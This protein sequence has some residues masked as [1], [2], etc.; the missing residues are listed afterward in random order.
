MEAL[1][2]DI[3]APVSA[4][5]GSA[6]RRWEWVGIE[7][8]IIT[9]DEVATRLLMSRSPTFSLINYPNLISRQGRI[10]PPRYTLP[11]G[12]NNLNNNQELL[13][14]LGV[15]SSNNTLNNQGELLTLPGTGTHNVNSTNVRQVSSLTYDESGWNDN[16]SFVPRQL[17]HR[18][19]SIT[20]RLSSVD[21]ELRQHL[22][23][24][25]GNKE[26][27]SSKFFN[28]EDVE[29]FSDSS[30]QLSYSDNEEDFVVKFD[31]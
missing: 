21:I 13:A 5:G 7:G 30:S 20:E 28:F 18:T 8:P 1:V 25:F 17:V 24:D 11:N 14:L 16:H 19:D 12:N 10:A 27:E 3:G 4:G 26:I 15:N 9:P 2:K 23:Y 22:S 31:P 6:S 29:K